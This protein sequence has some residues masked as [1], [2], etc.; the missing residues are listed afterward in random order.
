VWILM[1]MTHK[2]LLMGSTTPL[3]S[4][5]IFKDWRTKAPV[6]VLCFLS[7]FAFCFLGKG[8]GHILV[9]LIETGLSTATQFVTD[10]R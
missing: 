3:A 1:V 7:V 4:A 2:N 9:A 10:P 8:R 6:F 5:A